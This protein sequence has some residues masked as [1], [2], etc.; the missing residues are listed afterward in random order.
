MSHQVIRILLVDDHAVVRAGT[1]SILEAHPR[2]TVVGETDSGRELEGLIRL[3]QPDVLLLDINL[4]E[5]NGFQLLESLKPAFPDLKVVLFSAHCDAPY[6]RKALAL[7]ADGYITKTADNQVLC[8]ALVNVMEAQPVF[9]P[10]VRLHLS[11]AD[12][13][14]QELGLTPREQEI[15]VH[16][17]RGM[18]NRAIAKELMVS[19]KTVDTHVANLLK[20][21]GSASRAQLMA[22]A[23]GRGWL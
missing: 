14:R 3:K 4:P 7:K 15:L 20:K 2:L 10:D 23:Y 12:T 22:S 9:S 13:T 1:R 8:E 6:V 5:R 11:S 16:V 19:V 18:S 21:T 17:M